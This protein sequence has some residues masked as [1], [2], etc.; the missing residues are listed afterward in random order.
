MTETK[1]TK[2]LSLNS[3]VV[4]QAITNLMLF[5][6]VERFRKRRMHFSSREYFIASLEGVEALEAIKRR[7][8]NDFWAYVS[9]TLKDRAE[10]MLLEFS[11]KSLAFRLTLGTARSTYRV[12]KFILK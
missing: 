9:S 8:N 12:A 5:G 7:S 2:E 4:S 1:I 6:F 3:S 10:R 11:E